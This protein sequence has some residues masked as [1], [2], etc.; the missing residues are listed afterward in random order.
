MNMMMLTLH[1]IP[2]SYEYFSVEEED[3]QLEILSR[4]LALQQRWEGRP[5][6]LEFRIQVSWLLLK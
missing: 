6:E 4:D 2:T 5:Q 3:C 1:S